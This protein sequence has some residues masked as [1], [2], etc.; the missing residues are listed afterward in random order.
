MVGREESAAFTMNH[1]KYFT[2][3][4]TLCIRIRLAKYLEKL[5]HKGQY[6]RISAFKNITLI[7]LEINPKLAREIGWR[8]MLFNIKL[9]TKTPFITLM[10]K[11]H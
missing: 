6:I 3:A 10:A 4:H 1:S 7:T 9:F 11:S 2:P 8:S 5:L